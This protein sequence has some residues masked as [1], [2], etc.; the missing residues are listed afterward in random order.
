LSFGQILK[1]TQILINIG[2]LTGTTGFRNIIYM[3][4]QMVKYNEVM[5]PK[6]PLYS[7]VK[8]IA[9]LGKSLCVT[10]F[11]ILMGLCCQKV[12][13]SQF[14]FYLEL[15]NLCDVTGSYVTG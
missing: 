13:G 1:E 3:C 2:K 10:I 7:L 5:V 9:N 8:V 6:K 15:I 14:T 11:P 12:E 4:L